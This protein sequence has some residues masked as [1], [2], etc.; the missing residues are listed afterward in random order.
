MLANRIPREES[1]MQGFY[2]QVLGTPGVLRLDVGEPDFDTPGHIVEAAA[3]AARKGLTHYTSTWGI[4]ELRRKISEKLE[5]DNGFYADPRSELVVVDGGSAGILFAILSLVDPGDRV[6]IPDPGWLMYEPYVMFAGGKPVHY[7]LLE[8]E[9]G[10]KVDID[11]IERNS[12]GAKLIIVNSPSNPTGAV[13]SRKELEEIA[14]VAVESGALILSDEAYEKFVFSGSRHVSPVSLNGMKGRVVSVYSFSKTYAMTGWRIGYVAAPPTIAKAVSLMNLYFNA[15]PSS[16]S[17]AAALAALDGP[18]DFVEEARS[19]YER[20][21]DSAVSLLKGSSGI[22][23][24]EPRGAFYI[25]AG[26]DGVDDTV[27][28]AMRLLEDKGVS[29]MPGDVFGPLARGHV[30]I[31]LTLP[32]PELSEAIERLSEFME[33]R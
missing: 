28:F 1:V 19:E 23:F 9:E 29:V 20:R 13:H 12:M 22:R 18:Q 27:K 11:G 8:E 33:G 17:Q 26:L 2:E 21:R 3:E 10:F 7:P 32:V 31:S 24:V 4:P 30:R 14:D 15:C 16:I 25:F 6:L 5:K